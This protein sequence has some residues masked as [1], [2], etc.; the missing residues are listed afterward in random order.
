[1]FRI[2]ILLVFL[3][4]I[5]N[6]DEEYE[7]GEYEYMDPMDFLVFDGP[8][9]TNVS[10]TIDDLV[11]NSANNETHCYVAIFDGEDPFETDPCFVNT[12]GWVYVVLER[13]V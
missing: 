1:M 3:V 10:W 13:G 9:G 4:L 12:T 2:F 7:Y 11:R 8:N 5:T 6:A